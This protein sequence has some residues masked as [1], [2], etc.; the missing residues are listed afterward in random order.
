VQA[1]LTGIEPNDDEISS[2]VDQL[3]LIKRTQTVQVA[4][5]SVGLRAEIVSGSNE[6]LHLGCQLSF[7]SAGD[8]PEMWSA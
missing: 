4:V 8:I 7:T 1:A 6:N 2:L 3:E 5:P